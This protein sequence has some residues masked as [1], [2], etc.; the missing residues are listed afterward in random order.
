MIFVRGP[1]LYI[2]KYILNMLPCVGYPLKPY[3]I[4][5]NA[6]GIYLHILWSR[7]TQQCFLFDVQLCVKW[8]RMVLG[9][10]HSSVKLKLGLQFKFNKP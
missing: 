4:T 2:N 6:K 3:H 9:D 10:V 5:N 8:T 1:N 7:N